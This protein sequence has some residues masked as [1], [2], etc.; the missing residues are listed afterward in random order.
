MKLS[1]LMLKLTKPLLTRAESEAIAV[2]RL[3]CI[4]AVPLKWVRICAQCKLR[5]RNSTAA[6]GQF[7]CSL[8][9]EFKNPQWTRGSFHSP[10][11]RRSGKRFLRSRDKRRL[12]SSGKFS[13]FFQ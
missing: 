7:R 13:S 1:N 5:Q 10:G 11:A 3:S 9:E 12:K 6:A 8:K 4:H 2:F